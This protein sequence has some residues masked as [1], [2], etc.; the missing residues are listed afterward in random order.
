MRFGGSAMRNDRMQIVALIRFRYVAAA[1]VCLAI[2]SLDRGMHAQQADTDVALRAVVNA[3]VSAWNRHDMAAFRDLF[4]PDAQFVNVIGMHLDGRDAIY[5]HHAP[6]HQSG[7]MRH[8]TMTTTIRRVQ[9]LSPTAGVVHMHWISRMDGW[10]GRL[11]PRTGE[12]TLVLTRGGDT[13][14]IV[15]AHNTDA[16][17]PIGP[18]GDWLVL[19][20]IGGGL[21]ACIAAVARATALGTIVGSVTGMFVAA[22]LVAVLYW[23]APIGGGV[24]G[25]G[26]LGI[27]VGVAVALLRRFFFGR[28]MRRM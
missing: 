27:A 22:P 9:V 21:G 5:D 14:Q 26:V 4:S 8:S 11:R 13:W 23:D 6:S 15:S 12:M 17:L 28:V 24:F 18:F 10:L 16:A 1:V 19:A 25:F 3:S 20:V 2:I 7:W